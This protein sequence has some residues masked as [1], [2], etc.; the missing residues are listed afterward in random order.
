MRRGRVVGAGNLVLDD[1]IVV[2]GGEGGEGGVAAMRRLG[3]RQPR[4]LPPQ[5][6]PR[7]SARALALWSGELLP[8]D[9]L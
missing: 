5:V 1:E 3:P 6:P 8:E 9:L 4:G 7:T 2:L